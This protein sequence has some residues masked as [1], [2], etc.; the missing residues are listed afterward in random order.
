M[1]GVIVEPMPGRAGEQWRLY[2]Q[3]Q[4]ALAPIRDF[5]SLCEAA[6]CIASIE[7]LR[8]TALTFELSVPLDL[9]VFGMEPFQVIY[10]GQRSRYVVIRLS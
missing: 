7:G 3:G 1:A 8:E 4:D 10:R 6:Q 2:R 5:D 9:E